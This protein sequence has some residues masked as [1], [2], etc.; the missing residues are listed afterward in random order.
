MSPK[1]STASDYSPHQLILVHSVCLYISTVIGDY[2]DDLVIIGGLVP[3]L[4][5][6]QAPLPEGADAHVGTQDLDIGFSLGKFNSD[7]YQK[8]IE[9]LRGAGFIPDKNKNQNPTIQ[10]WKLDIPIKAT[11]DFL[12]P[13]TTQVEIGGTIKHLGK[14]FGAVI[15]PGLN[16]AFL[17]RIKM[18]ISGTTPFGENAERDI[19][20]CG[21]GA[22]IILKALAFDS[23]GEPK[24]AY[25]LFYV[26]RNY[27]SGHEEVLQHLLPLIQ[28]K[29]GEKAIAIL[30]RDFSNPSSVGSV[31][32]ARFIHGQPNEATQVE[33]AGYINQVLQRI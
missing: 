14:D 27:G 3:N 19:W 7:R 23:R 32:V 17:D 11:V 29:Y 16:L 13:Q 26:V 10:R 24:D 9:R 5:I 6:S 2:I 30:K 4:I 1:P 25:V 21:P 15:T 31:R 8:I 12:I 20:V 22:Y 33:V 28:N 18:S